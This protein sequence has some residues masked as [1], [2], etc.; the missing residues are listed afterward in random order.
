ME[1]SALKDNIVYGDD[2]PRDEIA[3]FEEITSQYINNQLLLNGGSKLQIGNG[4]FITV[5]D[6]FETWSTCALAR[7][8]INEDNKS[9]KR[10][11]YT[12]TI[13]YE[14]PSNQGSYI[15]LADKGYAGDYTNISC[16]RSSDKSGSECTNCTNFGWLEITETQN[17]RRVEI[18]GSAYR[19]YN[20]S[21][22]WIECNTD[23]QYWTY[24][25]DGDLPVG[26]EKLVWD[27]D[28][29]STTV[30]LQTSNHVTPYTTTDGLGSWIQWIK[31]IYE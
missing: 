30:T 5:T 9:D 16:Y 21:L 6:G 29:P 18:Y 17:V 23:R 20:A 14:L 26:F 1:C 3:S 25:A 13:Y 10:I 22:A 15:Y 4:E 8:E 24:N 11:D 12:L 2:D 7:I 27:L 19:S 28:T 31:V